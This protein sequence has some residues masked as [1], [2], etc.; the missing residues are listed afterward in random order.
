L[1]GKFF[2]T[3]Y[4]IDFE[5]DF[6]KFPTHEFSQVFFEPPV[7]I[8]ISTFDFPILDGMLEDFKFEH[9]LIK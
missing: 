8:S 3:P 7:P 5:K 9:S 1:F 4:L 6:K 2:I